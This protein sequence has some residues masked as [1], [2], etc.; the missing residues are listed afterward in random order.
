MAVARTPEFRS[1]SR[2]S[3][4]VLFRAAQ[5]VLNSSVRNQFPFRRARRFFF[6]IKRQTFDNTVHVTF[7]IAPPHGRFYKRVTVAQRYNRFSVSLAFLIPK[8]HQWTFRFRPLFLRRGSVDVRTAL[9]IGNPCTGTRYW[10]HL[11]RPNHSRAAAIVTKPRP[12]RLN[13]SSSGPT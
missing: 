9:R 5:F 2:Q 13:S 8:V 10:P 3:R 12:V 4:E 7:P 11:D 6:P 1:P